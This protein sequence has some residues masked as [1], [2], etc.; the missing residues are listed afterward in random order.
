MH[1]TVISAEDALHTLCLAAFVVERRRQ[2]HFLQACVQDLFFTTVPV[3][4]LSVLA[5]PAECD[6]D[7]HFVDFSLV[8]QA[9]FAGVGQKVQPFIVGKHGVIEA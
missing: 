2:G 9:L 3:H 8:R 4:T 7:S 5:V 6:V 1:I